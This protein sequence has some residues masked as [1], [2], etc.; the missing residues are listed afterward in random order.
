MCNRIQHALRA[1]TPKD[2]KAVK[3]AAE[4]FRANPAFKTADAIMELSTG[5]ALVSLLDEKGAPS[6]VQRARIMFPL[7][8]IGAITEGQRLDINRSAPRNILEYDSYFD[9]ESAYEVLT[10]QYAQAE[11]DA[12]EAERKEQEEREK[13]AKQQSG[14]SASAGKG[15]R[16]TIIGTMIGAVATSFARSIGTQTAKAITQGAKSKKTTT[17]SKSKSTK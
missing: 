5:E 4:T 8:S 14:K 17:S 6:V 11:K 16:R 15:I 1:F 12:Q 9:R 2:Q 13:E 3:A 7:S 10:A